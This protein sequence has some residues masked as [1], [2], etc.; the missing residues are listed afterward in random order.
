MEQIALQYKLIKGQSR[1]Q[2][3]YSCGAKLRMKIAT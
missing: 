1:G 3:A 2:L